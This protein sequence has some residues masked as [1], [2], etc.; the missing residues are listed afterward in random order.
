MPTGDQLPFGTSIYPD[1]GAEPSALFERARSRLTQGLASHEQP[2]QTASRPAT[3]EK[4][5]ILLVDDEQHINKM[6]GRRL[7]VS[8]FDVVIAMDGQ[9]G[10]T[11]AQTEHPDIIILDLMMP[12][13]NGYE[14]CTKLKQD[15]RYQEI[16]ILI[17]SAKTREK[18]E[19]MAMGCGAD[20]Y[21]RKPFQAK[22][23]LENIQTLLAASRR[24]EGNPTQRSEGR[25]V[26]L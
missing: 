16:P 11:K 23:L 22:E 12:K 1:D 2:P 19:K 9:E 21:L 7:E 25:Q 5:R 20:A 14:V 4:P 10:L 24:T 13:L 3:S 15:A 18:D 6:L 17:L 8:G 26:K